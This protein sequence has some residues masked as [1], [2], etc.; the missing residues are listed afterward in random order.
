MELSAPVFGDPGVTLTYSPSGNFDDGTATDITLRVNVSSSVG[1]LLVTPLNPLLPGSYRLT[2]PGSRSPDFQDFTTNFQISGV[3]GD[4][5]GAAQGDDTRTTAHDL[6]DVTNGNLVQASGV[7]GDD[8]FY[9][10]FDP[11]D[12]FNTPANPSANDVDLYHFH[13]SGS[14]HYALRAEVFAGR[15]G[16]PLDPALSLF[17]RDAEGNAA[18]RHHGR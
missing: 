11:N 14:D 4:T 10:N 9:A 15:I 17:R 6:G 18:V 2:V 8:P 1:E 3:E 16:S 12:Y 13:V 5:S 7:I